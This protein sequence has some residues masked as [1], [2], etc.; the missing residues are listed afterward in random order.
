M[1]GTKSIGQHGRV[2]AADEVGRIVD[3]AQSRQLGERGGEAMA[4]RSMGRDD[5]EGAG[6]S[7]RVGRGVSFDQ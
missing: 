4:S 5:V 3:G 6:R 2:G 7:V 1:L